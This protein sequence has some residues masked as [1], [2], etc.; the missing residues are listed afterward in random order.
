[1]PG[2]TLR[3]AEKSF[4][5]P[6]QRVASILTLTP[7][8]RMPGPLSTSVDR[9]ITLGTPAVPVQ[10]GGSRLHDGT[11]VVF[12]AVVRYQ[13]V[14]GRGYGDERYRVQTRGYYYH[15]INS[16]DEEIMLFHWHPDGKV[17]EP[18]LHVGSK[19]LAPNAALP[20]DAHVP[21][22]R[23]AFEQVALFLIEELGV[24]PRRADYADV[25]SESLAD[26]T[27]YRSWLVRPPQDTQ[28]PA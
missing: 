27:S 15:V 18:H 4:I 26:F 16:M 9:S 25:I 6:V 12:S 21:T 17:T 23:V 2:R 24:E 5:A 11:G 14:V 3:E 10:L 7:F 19:Q 22:S 28:G 20:S 1:M 8:L 13:L